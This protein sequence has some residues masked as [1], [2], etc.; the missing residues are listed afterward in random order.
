[1]Q[2]KLNNYEIRKNYIDAVGKRLIYF[3]KEG[4][5]IFSPQNE[6]VDKIEQKGF[7]DKFGLKVDC[8]VYYS[9]DKTH[10][11]GYYTPLK[12]LKETISK[13]KIVRPENIISIVI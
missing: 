10:D 1:M 2:K 9:Y 5:L 6:I 11:D 8:I 13:F 7:G 12:K 3:K 4:Y